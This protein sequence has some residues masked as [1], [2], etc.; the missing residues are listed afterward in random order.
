LHAFDEDAVAA[1]E[2]L[3]DQLEGVEDQ[4]RV[5]ARDVVGIDENRARGVA[6]DELLTVGNGIHRDGLSADED[7]HLGADGL[8]LRDRGG[9]GFSHEGGRGNSPCGAESPSEPAT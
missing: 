9:G 6:P 4:S 1:A 5:V 7:I 8:G 3:D 2:I